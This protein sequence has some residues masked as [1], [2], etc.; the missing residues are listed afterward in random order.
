MLDKTTLYF[1][2]HSL[3]LDAYNF[4]SS[5]ARKINAIEDLYSEPIVV[6]TNVENGLG[7]FAG[8]NI[9]KR[10]RLIEY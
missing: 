5:Y 1:E 3:S 7:I 4:C 2:V 10:N 8:D 6:F 9:S